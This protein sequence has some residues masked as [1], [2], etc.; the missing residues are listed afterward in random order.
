MRSF[1]IPNPLEHERTQASEHDHAVFFSLI[2]VPRNPER[3]CRALYRAGVPP[4]AATR[5]STLPGFIASTM[6]LGIRMV[7]PRSFVVS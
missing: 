5:P 1:P 3:L 6:A 4:A 2:A 7:A